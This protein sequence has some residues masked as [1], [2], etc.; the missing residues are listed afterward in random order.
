MS[1]IIP[2]VFGPLIQERRW[3]AWAWEKRGDGRTK[4]PRSAPNRVASSIDP[5]TWL[6]YEDAAHVGLDGTG[7]VFTGDGL[8][9][10]DLDDCR[11]PETGEIAA[12][13]RQIIDEFRSYT[14]VSPSSTGVK[15]LAAGAP[16]RLPG[17]KWQPEGELGHADVFVDR[18]FFTVTGQLLAGCPAEIRDAGDLGDAWDLMVRR[19]GAARAE[20][21]RSDV[22]VPEH[23]VLDE[24]LLGR[25]R[26]HPMTWARWTN[27][28]TGGSDR[29][30]DDAALATAMAIDGFTDAEIAAA[31]EDYE[32]GQ[33][34]QNALTGKDALRQVGRLLSIANAHR[35][36]APELHPHEAERLDVDARAVA[37]AI[38]KADDEKRRAHD[39]E[40]ARV[41]A[42][43]LYSLED[44]A[45]GD[46]ID[47]YPPE[48]VW[49]LPDFLPLG[50]VGGIGAAGGVGK[51][52]AALQLA[53][54]VAGGRDFWGL[55]MDSA[56]GVLVLSAEDD[57]EEIHRRL[58]RVLRSWEHDQD[59]R[60][61][62]EQL[63]GCLYVADRVGEDNLLT[64]VVDRTIVRTHMAER[65]AA[66]ANQITDVRL[67]I[68]DPL[69]RFRGGGANGEEEATRFVEAMEVIRRETDATVLAPAHLNKA[70]IRAGDTSQ[71]GF[72]GSSAL[73]D[74][75]RWAA[76]MVPMSEADAKARAVSAEDAQRWVQF[77]VPK[78]N[79]A[80]PI[81]P[82]W[83][84]R[85]DDG[86]LAPDEPP[87]IV[88]EQPKAE[89][90][91][92]RVVRLI[93]R[94]VNEMPMK[95]TDLKRMGGMSGVFRIGV[96]A[97]PGIVERGIRDGYLR[98]MRDSDTSNIWKIAPREHP[99]ERP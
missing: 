33:M 11:D 8:G 32:L 19:I 99:D 16:Q 79:Y 74:S 53:C 54:A 26:Q 9:G 68:V 62:V 71:S 84:W 24:A 98:K 6:T 63:R 58:H 35:P 48:R 70:S 22:P 7:F 66:T 4:V 43:P 1:S 23:G 85:G 41:K 90:D 10:V 81:A 27:G 83:L 29:S 21:D 57:R 2:E 47:E 93:Y 37:H 50:V 31:L 36:R 39:E 75:M 56:G 38:L 77:S 97:I 15:I 96:N 25:M 12:W 45:V 34:G 59:A 51:S 87:E 88:G 40:E 67:I 64:H 20:I 44:M 3:V 95:I 5:Q 28:K 52:T 13:A 92:E 49:I 14:E 46:L 72:R 65:I 69:A 91:Y 78:N 42:T 82:L 61:Y 73:V 94:A 89:A 17:H 60:P 86:V 30:A 76:M 55:G 80:P 18:R